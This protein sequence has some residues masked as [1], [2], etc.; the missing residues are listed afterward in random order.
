M[1]YRFRAV[2]LTIPAVF[3]A[4]K[5]YEICMKVQGTQHSQNGL[6]KEQGW[7]TAPY[8]YKTCYRAIVIVIK[9]GLYWCKDR[10]VN[11]WNIIEGLK[12][13]HYTMTS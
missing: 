11:Q 3:F 1:I 9:T 5:S 8:S 12:I 13:N 2:P 4:K 10:Y 7:G 6:E